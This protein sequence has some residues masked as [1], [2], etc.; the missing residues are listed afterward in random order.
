MT[1]RT[2]NKDRRLRCCALAALTIL[3]LF[4]LPAD[5]RAEAVEPYGAD[6]K[7]TVSIP[8]TAYI[9]RVEP[10]QITLVNQGTAPA[11]QVVVEQRA[12]GGMRLDGLPAPRAAAPLR[13]TGDVVSW[14]IAEIPAG[15]TVALV[16]TAASERLGMFELVTRVF[17][18]SE[19]RATFDRRMAW[20]EMRIMGMPSL[21]MTVRETRDPVARGETTVYMIEIHN[22]GSSP[23]TMIELSGGTTPDLSCDTASGPAGCRIGADTFAFE[24]YP[25][26]FTGESI[27]YQV[28]CLA[29]QEGS[30]RF[31]AV[32]GYQES[33]QEIRQEEGTFIF[34]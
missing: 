23:C 16:F 4:A 8:R 17:P 18:D 33:K 5:V 34:E 15:E 12:S 27:S 20:T 28:T 2:G 24:A 3:G 31:T 21:R 22:E 14:S 25:I 32:L 7:L 26:L 30:A 29:C 1:Y 19:A 6:L 11:R 9:R 10:C 13:D